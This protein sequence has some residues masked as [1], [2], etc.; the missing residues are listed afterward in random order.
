MN[1]YI[2]TAFCLFIF[3]TSH[4]QS[5]KLISENE[6]TDVNTEQFN[7][8]NILSIPNFSTTNILTFDY[9]RSLN[10]SALKVDLRAA[11]T[12]DRIKQTNDTS[13]GNHDLTVDIIDLYYKL[14]KGNWTFA[15]GR[16]KVRFGVGYV[17]S[18]TDI[19]SSPTSFDNPIDRLHQIKGND[20]VQASYVGETWQYDLYVLPDTERNTEGYYQ[21]HSIASRFYTYFNSFEMA[22]L[23]RVDFAGRYQIGGNTTVAIGQKLEL[24]AEGLFQSENNVR[25]PQSGLFI[26]KQHNSL[27]SLIGSQWSPKPNWNVVLEYFLLTEGY[28]STEWNALNSI[29]QNAR[30]SFMSP[31]SMQSIVGQEGLEQI[32]RSVQFPIRKNH[33][34]FRIARSNILRHFELEYLT[35]LGLDQ[36]RD[37]IHRLAINYSPKK[38]IKVYIHFQRIDNKFKN[39]LSTINHN[40]KIRLGIKYNLNIRKEDEKQ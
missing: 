32:S 34:F 4:G 14:Y 20:L 1:Y 37:G 8:D 7:P 3:L 6:L 18:P 17:A 5:I 23:G 25:Y 30:T 39:S 29:I 31:D 40:H 24:H 35:F 27:R 10:N 38:K 12:Y 33:L 15:L 19:I 13:F 28:N 36:W 22:L 16:K 11:S 21:D 2:V 26:N 9:V